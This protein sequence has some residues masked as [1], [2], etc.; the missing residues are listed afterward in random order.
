M[1]DGPLNTKAGLS[2][3]DFK[4]GVAEMNRSMRVLSSEFKASA[5]VLGDWSKDA[6]G[7]EQRIGYLNKAID[8]QKDKVEALKGQQ[9]AMAR[10]GK[11][12]A[13]AEA[14]MAIKSNK[15]TEEL[16]GMQRELGENTDALGQ[17]KSGTDSAAKSQEAAAN[18]SN[19]WKSVLGGLGTALKAVGAAVAAAVAAIAGM[20]IAIVRMAATTIKPASDLAETVS[21]VG[22]VFGESADEVIKFGEQAAKG[23]GMSENAA[24]TAAGTYGN[25]FRAMGFTSDASA[26]M[27]IN[28]VQL[29]GDLASFNNMG[30]EEVLEKLRAGL[31]GEAEPLKSLGI[32]MSAARIEAELMAMGIEK[33]NGEFTAAQKAQAAYNIMLKDSALAQGDFARTSGGLANQQRILAAQLENTKASI[34]TALLPVV[35]QAVTAFNGL[36]NSPAV[37]AWLAGLTTGLGQVSAILKPLLDSIANFNGD[38]ASVATVATGVITQLI[39]SFAAQA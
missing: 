24:L 10:E 33:V 1:A 16:N 15:A 5:A 29:A 12:T 17:M 4:A 31:T 38:F 11:L 35:T 7:L 39:S 2:V 36:F 23:L 37:Q 20:G 3:G 18:A 28:L 13:A 19:R 26:E 22:I 32:N 9:A 21:K 25:L 14:E 6:T 27:S 34:G 30:T 8:L